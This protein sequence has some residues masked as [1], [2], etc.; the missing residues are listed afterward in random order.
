MLNVV[1]YFMQISHFGYFWHWGAYPG[2]ISPFFILLGLLF[3]FAMLRRGR[4]CNRPSSGDWHNRRLPPSQP[5]AED[6][7]RPT[8]DR[9]RYS[10]PYH[11]AP[12]NP[13]STYGGRNEAGEA[14]SQG[15][16]TVRVQTGVDV[17]AG[18]NTVRVNT[19][20]DHTHESGGQPT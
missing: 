2:R 3:V 20:D 15:T 9:A 13:Y 6:L 19:V 7:Q 5:S 4:S 18:A 1:N 12:R 16:P 11:N 8:G 17:N 10:N 14:T